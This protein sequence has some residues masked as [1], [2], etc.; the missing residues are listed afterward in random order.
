[1]QGCSSEQEKFRDLLQRFRK[2]NST[3]QDWQLLLTRQPSN[4]SV[5]DFED[6]VRLFYS[7]QEVAT[8]NHEQLTMFQQPVAHINA[9][10]SSAAAKS[11]T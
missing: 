3:T 4:V 10:H 9:R 11:L 7:N 8:Y 2:G 6:A 5:A 1:M